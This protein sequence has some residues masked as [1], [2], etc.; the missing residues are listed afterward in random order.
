MP[1]KHNIFNDLTLLLDI[2]R[3]RSELDHGVDAEFDHVDADDAGWIH[4]ARDGTSQK[5]E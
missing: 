5:E 3:L 2:N 4:A 1:S